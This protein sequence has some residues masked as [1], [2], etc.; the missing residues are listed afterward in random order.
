MSQQ[1]I[2]F[3]ML[4]FF[5]SNL[6]PNV[7]RS[8]FERF[9]MRVVSFASL[10]AAT[11]LLAGCG[12]QD[13]SGTYTDEM[14]VSEYKFQDDGKVTITMMGVEQN[15]TFK[16]DGNTLKIEVAPNT[17][18]VLTIVDD[19]TLSVGPLRLKKVNK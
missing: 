2:C 1:A 7:N 14:G 13:F 6:L 5:L 11:L 8:L 4:Y 19:N 12:G 15:V 16:R 18:S 10:V 17:A 3:Q 9:F